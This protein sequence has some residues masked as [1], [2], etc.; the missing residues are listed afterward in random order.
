MPLH[1]AQP[2]TAEQLIARL[3][4]V[5]KSRIRDANPDRLE[6]LR[7]VTHRVDNVSEIVMGIVQRALIKAYQD[8]SAELTFGRT[9]AL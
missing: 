8:M 3:T 1:L 5:E 7:H 9:W 4:E 6:Y 2:K